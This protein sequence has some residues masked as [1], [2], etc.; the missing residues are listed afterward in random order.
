[1]CV[2]SM[3]TDHYTDKWK[4]L[5]YS[6]HY[7]GNTSPKRVTPRYRRSRP[8]TA[9]FHLEEI[10]GVSRLLRTGARIRQTQ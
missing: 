5:A 9:P 2:V 6:H 7:R 3:I 4:E 8:A 10:N 1:M